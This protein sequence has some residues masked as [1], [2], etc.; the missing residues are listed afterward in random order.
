M[1]IC[2]YAGCVCVCDERIDDDEMMTLTRTFSIQASLITAFTLT[3][4][5]YREKRIGGSFL[6]NTTEH[7]QQ[8]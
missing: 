6:T 7:T 3:V 5:H 2:V 4:E 1:C 8:R